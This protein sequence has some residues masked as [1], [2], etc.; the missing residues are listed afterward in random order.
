MANHPT[1]QNFKGSAQGLF[2]SREIQRLMRTE[3]ERAQ[4]YRYPVVLLLI[5]ID[6]LPQLQDLYGFEVK[7]DILDGLNHRLKVATRSSDFLACTMDDRLL[8]LVPHTPPEGVAS[9]ARRILSE[10]RNLGL[11]CDGR[12]MRVSVSIGGAHNE[13]RENVVFEVML[14]VAEGGNEVA[15]KGGGD[16]YVHSELY[17][18]FAAKQARAPAPLPAEPAAAPPV[19]LTEISALIGDKIREMF[20]LSGEDTGLVTHIEREVTAQL[21]RELKNRQ[22]L[23]TTQV[24]KEDPEYARKIE[25]LERRISKLTDQL[26]TTENQLKSV[27]RGKNIDP[28]IASIY[29]TVQGLED[30]D[31]G[32]ELKR[33]LMSKIFEANMDLRR[34]RPDPA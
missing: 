15:Q 13:R 30:D 19:D 12:P 10:A 6:R 16:R 25:I 21:L 1:A 8:V 9:M 22:D 14:E 5:T 17:D 26:G 4:R 24:D 34:K 3:F 33:E 32:V 11:E 29:D 20:G 7:E 27:L 28:G 2:S 31:A 23:E 18:F